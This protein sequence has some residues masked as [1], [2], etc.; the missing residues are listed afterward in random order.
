LPPLVQTNTVFD[1][2][3]PPSAVPPKMIP[4]SVRFPHFES[5]RLFS[6]CA[7]CFFPRPFP[8]PTPVPS[9]FQILPGQGFFTFTGRGPFFLV[10]KNFPNAVPS[11]AMLSH[12][13]PTHFTCQGEI[14]SRRSD[15]H[16]LVIRS[17]LLFVS[18][19][20]SMRSFLSKDRKRTTNRLYSSH[21]RRRN[22]TF[23]F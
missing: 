19:S 2:L 22:A 10:Q 13:P 14:F 17:S 12:V 11:C 7:S 16:L 23:F 18:A 3:R 9:F 8:L 20:A 1:A 21:P 4:Q 5:K 6:C 15:F